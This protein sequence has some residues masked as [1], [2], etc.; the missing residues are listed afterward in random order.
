MGVIQSFLGGQFPRAVAGI[1][2]E[3]ACR[4]RPSPGLLQGPRASPGV[5][6]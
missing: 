3:A 1:G 5:G 4:R 2:A 6:G